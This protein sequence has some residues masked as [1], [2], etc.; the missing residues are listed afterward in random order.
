MALV[1]NEIKSEAQTHVLIIA[2]GGYPYLSGGARTIPQTLNGLNQLGQLTSPPVSAEAFY[3]KVMQLHQTGSWSKPLGS[4]ELLLSDAPGG[5]PVLPG[6]PHDPATLANIKTAYRSWKNRCDTRADNVAIFFFCGHGLQKDDHYLLPEDFGSDPAD[7]WSSCFA[8]D[9]TRRAFHNC[10]ADTQCFFVDSCRQVTAEML[11]F[12]LSISPL[13][14]P[15]M[16]TSDCQYNLTLKAAAPNEAAYGKKNEASF[17]TQALLNAMT[18]YGARPHNGIWAVQMG[19]IAANIN[20]YMGYIKPSEVYKQRCVSYSS[21]STAIIQ[22][23]AP[24]EV[25]LLV[26]CDP[27]AALAHAELSYFNTKTK[28]TEKRA[29]APD[30]WELDLPAGI[31]RLNAT[32]QDA[33]YLN[34]EDHISVEPPPPLPVNGKLTC[35]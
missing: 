10:K 20:A 34:S 7:P 15:S 22:F 18:G 8:F 24:P 29:P 1:F 17:F 33:P 30:P 32:F 5:R 2:V 11:T 14:S 26:S 28:R 35:V 12:A 27:A 3:E 31:Y 19:M 16:F 9:M 6:L 4:V 23:A 13:E 21:D 25:K